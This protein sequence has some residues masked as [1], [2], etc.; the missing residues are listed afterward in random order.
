MSLINLEEALVWA[1]KAINEPFRRRAGTEGFLHAEDVLR[2]MGRD[3][4]ADS[5]M[6]Q[7]VARDDAPVIGIHQYG[8]SL[9]TAGR[10]DKAM[11]IFM[12]NRQRH[13][14]DMF[15]T[16]VGLA[17]GY[18]ALGDTSK[19]IANWEIALKNIPENQKVNLPVYEQALK[20]LREKK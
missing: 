10:K 13:R 1:E 2:A 11:T 15:V 20:A 5:V 14:D 18:T 6:D 4:D 7:A 16:Y 8:T 17:R 3:G 19:A 9:I 12:L